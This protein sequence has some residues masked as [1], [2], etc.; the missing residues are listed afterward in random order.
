MRRP[1]PLPLALILL[2]LA[3]ALASCGGDDDG[4]QIEL[5][6]GGKKLTFPSN[7]TEGLASRPSSVVVTCADAGTTVKGIK[8]SSWGKQT[9]AGIGTAE[10]NDCDP[11]CAAGETKS[12][13]DAEVELSRPE[14]CKSKR[15]YT[16]LELTYGEDRPK[17]APPRIDERFPCA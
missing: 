9:A 5:G 17:G 6:S 2:P 15:Q 7:C 14:S 10:V 13:P 12:Y 16:R 8:W 3:L 4:I 1:T 11:N